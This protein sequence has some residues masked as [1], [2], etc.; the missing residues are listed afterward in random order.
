MIDLVTTVRFP[1]SWGIKREP[2]R[3]AHLRIDYCNGMRFDDNFDWHNMFYDAVQLNENQ[4]ALIGP[5][6]YGIK[7]WMASNAGFADRNGNPLSYQFFDLDRVSYTIVQTKE[8]DPDIVMLSSKAD[9]VHIAANHND[10]FFNGH[11]VMVTLQRNNPIR[12]IEQWM[13][14]H[15]RNHGIDGFLIYDNSSTDYQ[16]GELDHAISR[17]YLKVKV[18]PWPYPYG[19][20]G[21]DHAPWDSDYGQ[22]VM[23]EHAKYRYLSNAALVLNNDIDELVV[24]MGPTLDQIQS[25]LTD[26]PHHCLAYQGRWI[27][28]YDLPRQRSAHEVAMGARRFSDYCCTDASNRTGI[29]HKWMLV[30]SPN[31]QYQWMVHRIAGPYGVS[32]DLFYGHYLAMNTNWSWKRDVFAGKP[33][34][35]R[36]NP[37]LHTSLSRMES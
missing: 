7:E 27:E 33:D 32:A 8:L 37:W 15:Y 5:P 28:P 4:M 17:P 36:P 6:L 3:P 26:G 9:P 21:S 12:W 30:P 20:Q 13:D 10:G 35:L 24:T 25:Q 18:V 1:E 19:P 34:D 2:S 22:Y 31:L 11:R 23:L 16:I 14:Y 29:G